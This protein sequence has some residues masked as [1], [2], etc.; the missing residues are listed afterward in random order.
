MRRIDGGV[1]IEVFH[2]QLAFHIGAVWA[3]R[4]M[5]SRH[6]PLHI[7][8]TLQ[9]TVDIHFILFHVAGNFQLGNRHLPA[10]AI[11]ATLGFDNPVQLRRPVRH[12][13]GGINAIEGQFAAPADRL[14]PVEQRF[15]FG[16]PLQRRYG[17]LIQVHLLFI[18]FSIKGNFSRRQRLSFHR[19]T[20][21]HGVVGHFAAEFQIQIIRLELFLA[22]KRPVQL[23]TLHFHIQ[24]QTGF[25]QLRFGAQGHGHR[26]G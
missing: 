3:K 10:A 25:R 24:R 20:K 17:Q 8:V 22:G 21:R 5:Q 19:G 1:E 4:Q 9:R 12:L 6:F 18:A 7:A 2:P 11:Q 14:L 16:F 23:L 26:A 15:Q 13:F